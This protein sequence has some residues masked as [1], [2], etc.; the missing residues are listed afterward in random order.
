MLSKEN[1]KKKFYSK[2]TETSPMLCSLSSWNKEFEKES[3]KRAP[4]RLDEMT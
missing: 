2:I 1:F 4:E 3:L